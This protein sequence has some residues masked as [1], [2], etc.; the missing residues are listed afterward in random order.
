MKPFWLLTL[1]CALGFATVFAQENFR[2]KDRWL[3]LIDYAQIKP[4]MLRNAAPH[5]PKSSIN[6][7]T[8]YK[9][10][11]EKLAS[12]KKR[13]NKEVEAFLALP[14]IK[15]LNPSLVHLGLQEA[16]ETPRFE[17]SYWQWISAAKLTASELN[18]LAP[19][20][21]V[22]DVDAKDLA[23]SQKNY[24][25]ALQDWMLLFPKEAEQLF[26]HPAMKA[27]AVSKE[28]VTI[29]AP[30]EGDAYLYVNVSETKPERSYFKSGNTE[31]DNARY[32]TYLKAWYHRF[33][34]EDFY[35]IYYPNQLEE[36]KKNKETSKA[37]NNH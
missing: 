18:S 9:A 8:E 36:W 14:E 10:F 15:K 3:A 29:T 27:H 13:Y 25:Y 24:E 23:L 34:E 2:Q 16:V 4:E 28:P 7:E 30:A 33:H 19:H 32:N 37:N 31:L 1:S 22:A 12:W 5:F 26:N 35:K 20:L 21:P 6:N 11:T 17:N